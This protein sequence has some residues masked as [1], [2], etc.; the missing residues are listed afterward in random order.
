MDIQD[1]HRYL[2][3]YGINP[4]V[5]RTAIMQYLLQSFNHP[6]VDQIY[7]DLFPNMPTLSKTTIYNT[8]KL[9]VDKKAAKA[10]FIDERNVRYE[11]QTD[12]HAHFKC[13]RCNVIC[14]VPLEVKE[15]PQFRGDSE[16]R[17]D[18]TQINFLGICGKCEDGGG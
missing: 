16:L 12:L 4:S 11:A 5:Q 2:E 7:A 8:L 1:V 15:V 14:E 6:T 17:L 3:R 10:I 13:R 9:F 18:E